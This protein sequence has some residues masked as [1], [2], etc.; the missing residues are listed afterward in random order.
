MLRNV[1]QASTDTLRFQTPERKMYCEPHMSNPHAWLFPGA[2]DDPSASD[3][4]RW[5]AEGAA[6]G[7]ARMDPPRRP[8]TTGQQ[9]LG[10][11][12]AGDTA[13]TGVDGGAEGDEPRPRRSIPAPTLPRPA[14]SVGSHSLEGAS[15]RPWQ[16]REPS[17]GAGK[18]DRQSRGGTLGAPSATTAA[19]AGRQ[20]LRHRQGAGVCAEPLGGGAACCGGGAQ[21]H[22]WHP[23]CEAFA[24]SAEA[25]S[26]LAAQNRVLRAALE[27][28]HQARAAAS[29]AVDDGEAR[30]QVHMRHAT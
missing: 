30:I 4:E 6:A 5:P 16:S 20:Q 25:A 21:A 14:G 8:F 7:S 23:D 18:L 29:A 27:S 19:D 24:E 10:S 12:H 9:V 15:Q 17:A 26:T 2:D 13:G 22:G 28:V 1:G 11:R 3:A